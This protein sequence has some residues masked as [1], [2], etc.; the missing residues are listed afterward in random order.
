M[1]PDEFKNLKRGDL[2][3]HHRHREPYTV[4]ENYGTHVTAMRTVNMT[5]PGEWK[6]I[7]TV[8]PD[9]NDEEK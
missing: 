7:C 1:T 6:L 8:S 4:D 9:F 5:T 3:S 2:V